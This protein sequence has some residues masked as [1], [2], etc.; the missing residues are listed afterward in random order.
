M[1]FVDIR[2]LSVAA[3][4]VAVFLLGTFSHARL[5][6][7]KKLADIPLESIPKKLG[8]WKTIADSELDF[9]SQEILKLDRYIKR[10]Y[11]HPNGTR[12]IL[13]IGYWRQQTG[14][15]QAAKHSP[16]ICLPANGW[17]V[18]G[19]SEIPMNVTS[20]KGETTLSVR[21]LT[22][23]FRERPHAF[24]YWFFSGESEYNNEWAALFLN[25]YKKLTT[26]KSDG[27]IVE[28][29]IPM[30]S[31]VPADQIGEEEKR[32]IDSFLKEL[33]PALI[34]ASVDEAGTVE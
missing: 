16:L 23:S 21:R 17:S 31:S 18:S 4:L 14:D 12:A 8:E 7:N 13:Y 24:Y 28:I 11:E 34:K 32:N 6:E 1:K 25:I 22:A 5:V 27:G 33:Y 26:G 9:R 19:K 20:S 15:K 3:V 10:T 29:S 30:D 2:G